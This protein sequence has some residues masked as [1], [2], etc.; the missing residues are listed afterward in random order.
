MGVKPFEERF[1]KI[2]EEVGGGD[3]KQL[4]SDIEDLS[5][6]LT[7][8]FDIVKRRS[9]AEA[10]SQAGLLKVP[11]QIPRN[12]GVPAGARGQVRYPGLTGILDN[13]DKTIAKLKS[14][15]KNTDQMEALIKTI[16]VQVVNPAPG[17]RMTISD[18]LRQ[19]QTIGDSLSR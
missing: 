14:S 8:Q 12:V 5:D 18:E 17:V 15:G 13:W 1:A 7:E 4:K 6:K 19:L 2:E 3:E 11:S 9:Q 16:R 10:Q